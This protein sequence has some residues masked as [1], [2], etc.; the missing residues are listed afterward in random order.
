MAKNRDDFSKDTIRR[1]AG[2]VG[3]RCSFP[4]CGNPTI[5]ASMEN[6][7]KVS[8]IGVAAHIC[9]AAEGGPRYNK[10]MSPAE[11]SDI[12]NCI[13]M[14][15]T[16]SRVIDTDVNTYTVE[17]LQT[18]KKDAEEAAARALANGSFFDEYYNSNGDNLQILEQMFSDLILTGQYDTLHTMLEQYKTSLSEPYKEFVLRYKIIHDTYCRRDQ[19]DNDLN[20]YCNLPNKN[21]ADV[22]V[23]LFLSFHMHDELSRVIKFCSSQVLKEYAN[24]ALS[25]SLI[26]R[27]FIP[28]GSASPMEVPDEVKEIVSK[29]VLNYIRQ[30][31]IV[32]SSDAMGQQFEFY[33]DEFF[34][35]AL[36]AIYK[37]SSESIYGSGDFT[38]LTSGPDFLF[39]KDNID[40]I[41]L[42][43][44][45]LQEYFWSQF[46][47][48]L[49][50]E[51]DQFA[52]YYEHCPN[53]IRSRPG[54]QRA[55]YICTILS[56]I[57]SIDANELLAFVNV[58]NMHGIFLLY[59]DNLDRNSAIDI[60]DEHG[61]LY[62]KDSA[63]IA[64]KINKSIE[65]DADAIA[66]LKRY[67][68]SY[69]EDFYF[70]LL[71]AK[72]SDTEELRAKETNWLIEN[73]DKMRTHSL[74]D[75]ISFLRNHGYWSNLHALSKR[76]L[77]NEYVFCIASNLF[78]SNQEEYIRA[79]QKLL[80][81]L[82]D[83]GWNRPWLYFNLGLIHKRYGYVEEAIRSFQKNMICMVGSNHLL[84]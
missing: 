6:K 38:K 58:N 68:D 35:H 25:N 50:E 84:P 32:Y 56:D 27:V 62:R 64:I 41:K 13:W 83:V 76:H 12:S 30:T 15:Q 77:P 29:Y 21:G 20:A 31:A 24:L 70:H 57:V 39:I 44:P 55:R 33:S 73:L 42:L 10:N 48:F 52:I 47:I 61:Y 28:I 45:V 9:A 74:S 51:P 18:W 69:A 65:N 80:Q 43:D 36:S 53:I 3:Y 63:Y 34:Y 7:T 49:V 72:H 22:L 66:F 26:E 79:S 19:L 54:I 46:L 81:G 75:Y 40:K 37:L 8:I 16:H 60:L 5:G 14:C 2:R 11:R 67:Q 59:L 17:R 78:E 1:A 4:G 82:V 23:G 71:L